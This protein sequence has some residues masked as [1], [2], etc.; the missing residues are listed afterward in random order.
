METSQQQGLNAMWLL[1]PPEFLGSEAD[2]PKSFIKDCEATFSPSFDEHQMVWAASQN[3]RGDADQWWTKYSDLPIAWGPFKDHLR[4]KYS[5]ES[6]LVA[7]RSK[8]YG[9]V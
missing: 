1:A 2:D 6:L 5:D 4:R 9:G 7:L 8:L 3:L